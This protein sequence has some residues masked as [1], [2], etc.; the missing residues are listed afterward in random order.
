M[1]IFVKDKLNS[2]LDSAE[3]FDIA[4]GYFQISGW[5]TFADSVEELLKKGGKV[6]L[7]IG[8]VSREYLLPQTA[9]FL[10]HLIKNPQIEARTIKPRL[11]HAKVFMAKTDKELKLL[12]GSSNITF[13][14]MEANIEL[15]TH[16][17]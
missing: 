6:R 15:N 14:G 9:R 4:T 2:M 13:G 3:S 11:L 8:D 12:F 16:E 17:I 1:D 10:L 7:L 5:K